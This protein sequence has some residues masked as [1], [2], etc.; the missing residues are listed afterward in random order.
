[1]IGEAGYETSEESSD[2]GL[3]W[4]CLKRLP[5]TH[6]GLRRR[7]IEKVQVIDGTP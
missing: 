6:N 7:S 1:M 5:S 2:A 4:C 3:T